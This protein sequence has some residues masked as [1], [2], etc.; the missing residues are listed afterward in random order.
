MA[1]QPGITAAAKSVGMARKRRT[2]PI[3]QSL[4]RKPR[5][6]AE[7]TVAIGFDLIRVRIS[8]SARIR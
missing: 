7:L 3:R 6:G 4:F 1:N 5:D 8:L 2:S